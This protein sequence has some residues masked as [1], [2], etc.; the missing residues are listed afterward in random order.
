[1]LAT[2]NRL[3]LAACCLLASTSVLAAGDD[4]DTTISLP[5]VVSYRGTPVAIHEPIPLRLGS[6]TISRFSFLASELQLRTASRPWAPLE[7]F[8]LIDL[9]EGI[10]SLAIPNPGEPI[11]GLSFVL[12]LPEAIN[13][14]DPA[15]FPA[16]HPLDPLHNNLHWK[17]SDG[18][19]FFALEGFAPPERTPF[20][21]HLGHLRNRMSISLPMDE[22]QRLQELQ[23]RVELDALWSAG[24]PAIPVG[25][26]T[27]SAQDCPLAPRLAANAPAMFSLERHR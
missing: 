10:D 24:D 16:G 17:W 12:G 20:L 23:L 11:T 9:R 2:S 18:Y 27:H 5:L 1:M 14:G 4:A 3:L 6:L 7:G 19:I 21:Y 13:H 15:R 22:P 8:H 26:I 25:G